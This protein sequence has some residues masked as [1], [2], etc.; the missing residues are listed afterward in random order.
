M[1]GEG[2]LRGLLLYTGNQPGLS[3]QVMSEQSPEGYEWAKP[4]G[5]RIFQK[6]GVTL[7]RE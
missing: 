7:G 6:E 4:L 3:S 1:E 2:G 5:A